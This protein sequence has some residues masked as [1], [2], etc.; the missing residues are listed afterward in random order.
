[1]S[2]QGIIHLL[3]I[4]LLFLLA[5]SCSRTEERIELMEETF[6]FM[7]PDCYTTVVESSGSEWDD[8]W[9]DLRFGFDPDCYGRLKVSLVAADQFRIPSEPGTLVYKWEQKQPY[10]DASLILTDSTMTAHFNFTHF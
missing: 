7:F 8:Y 6:G 3:L 2:D 9:V 10:E 1:M 4:I 5:V